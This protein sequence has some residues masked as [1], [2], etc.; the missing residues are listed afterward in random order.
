MGCFVIGGMTREA[1]RD[2]QQAGGRRVGNVA[3]TEAEAAGAGE[4]K[5]QLLLPAHGCTC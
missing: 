1:R 4:K 3:I 2:W 5:S